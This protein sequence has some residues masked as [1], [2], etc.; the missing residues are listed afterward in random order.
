MIYDTKVTKTKT[1]VRAKS[2]RKKKTQAKTQKQPVDPRP[3]RRSTV[4][5]EASPDF[6]HKFLTKNIDGRRVKVGVLVGRVDVF[7]NIHI[8]WSKTNVKLNDKFDREKGIKMALDRSKAREFVPMPQS[9]EKDAHK[10]LKR[11]QRY[12]KSADLAKCLVTSVKNQMVR[13]EDVAIRP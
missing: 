4:K 7:Q 13:I 10:F 11:C 5:T 2:K 3:S 1:K 12:F 8:G 6:I 9:I